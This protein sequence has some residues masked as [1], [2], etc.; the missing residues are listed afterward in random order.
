MDHM[1]LLD[2]VLTA[3]HTSHNKIARI[4]LIIAEFTMLVNQVTI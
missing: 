1:E 2:I 3:F 4:G